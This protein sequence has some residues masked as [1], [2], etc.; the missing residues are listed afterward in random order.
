MLDIPVSQI[1]DFE[2][3]LLDMMEERYPDILGQ[4]RKTGDLTKKDENRLIQA[5]K[6]YK[7]I[8][9]AKQTII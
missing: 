1:Q 9:N 4:I 2:K 8:F 3:G 5:L 6:E 7:K